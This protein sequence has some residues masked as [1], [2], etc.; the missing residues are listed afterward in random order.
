MYAGMLN[1][2][3]NMKKK[4]KKIVHWRIILANNNA[5]AGRFGF[6]LIV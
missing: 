3:M 6:G 1:M 4:K 2:D 5:L